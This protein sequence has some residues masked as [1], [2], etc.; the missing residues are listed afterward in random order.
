MAHI[1]D[2]HAFYDRRATASDALKTPARQAYEVLHWGF[3]AAPA[4]AGLDKFSDLLTNW[5]N[6]LAP[7]LARVSPLSVHA[8]MMVV[9][10][11]EIVAALLVALKPRIGAWV[12]AAWLA[13]IIVD[14]ALLGHAWDIALRDFGL[15][16]G[17]IALARLTVAHD[18]H[19]IA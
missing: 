14:L 6:Y 18:Q 5:D 3:V 17:A 13:G 4:I 12:V 2:P 15:M 9:G 1:T 10:A 8:T 7:A 19:E 11:I 16:L